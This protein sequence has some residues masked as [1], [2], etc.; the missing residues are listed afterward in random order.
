M[1]WCFY[2]DKGSEYFLYHY[3]CPCNLNLLALPAEQTTADGALHLGGQLANS[4][5][6]KHQLTQHT[7]TRLLPDLLTF[8]VS[9]YVGESVGER[10]EERRRRRDSVAFQ[11]DFIYNWLFLSWFPPCFEPLSLCLS[12]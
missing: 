11:S 1:Y 9:V 7:S 8:V 4:T 2:S 5:L 10:E 6:Q 3:S 12:A